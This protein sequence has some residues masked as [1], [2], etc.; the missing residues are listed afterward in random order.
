MAQPCTYHTPLFVVHNPRIP[1][2]RATVC[3]APT[4][5]PYHDSQ[6]PVGRHGYAPHTQLP[7]QPFTVPLSTPLY[8]PTLKSMSATVISISGHCAPSCASWRA[9]PRGHVRSRAAGGPVQPLTRTRGPPSL[10]PASCHAP[11]AMTGSSTRAAVGWPPGGGASKSNATARTG[12]VSWRYGRSCSRTASY[13]SS[14]LAAGLDG[15]RAGSN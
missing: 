13:W 14:H 9:A 7:T 4:V 3:A 2:P 1:A 6:R 5:R 15:G 10:V 12:S 11:C 8:Y